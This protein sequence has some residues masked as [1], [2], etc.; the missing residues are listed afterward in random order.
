MI[1]GYGNPECK[2]D[3]LWAEI[4]TNDTSCVDVLRLAASY[5]WAVRQ[6][7]L[8]E[9]WGVPDFCY[10]SGPM[11]EVPDAVWAGIP[12]PG[13][14]PWRTGCMTTPVYRFNVYV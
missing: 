1:V 13:D 11:N 8:F 6:D 10:K 5:S 12:G 3:V 4:G 14:E 2:G 9:S 7:T